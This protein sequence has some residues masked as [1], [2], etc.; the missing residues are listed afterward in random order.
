MAC[1]LAGCTLQAGATELKMLTDAAKGQAEAKADKK[2]LVLFFTGSDWCGFCK[3]LVR[4]VFEKPEFVDYAAKHL[5]MV[6]LDFP[7][8]KTLPEA[9]KKANEALKKQYKIEGFP[10]L[11]FLD[12]NGKKL[13]E[14]VGYGGGGPK[15]LIEKIDRYVKK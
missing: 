9:Q 5:V 3:K 2:L 4:E 11:V 14:E 6:E 7:S 8:G 15:P 1:F 10:T 12:G 13:G